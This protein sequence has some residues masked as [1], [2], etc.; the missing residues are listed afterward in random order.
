MCATRVVT[1]G[2]GNDLYKVSEYGRMFYVSMEGLGFFATGSKSI[3]K[4]GSLHQALE[5]IK[6]YTGKEIA[7]IVDW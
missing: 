1:K 3:G 4:A 7:K 5:L 2:G 6:A